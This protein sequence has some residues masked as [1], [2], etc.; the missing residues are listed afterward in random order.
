MVKATP[1]VPFTLFPGD[2]W[3]QGVV[4]TAG[5]VL[6]K[7]LAVGLPTVPSQG[8][9]AEEWIQSFLSLHENVEL[10]IQQVWGEALGLCKPIHTIT[11]AW[12]H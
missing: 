10:L 9:R 12:T 3:A 7:A 5:P 2:A 11:K 1:S 4:S 6:Q 8:L